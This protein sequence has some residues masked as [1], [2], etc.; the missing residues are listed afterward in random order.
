MRVGG[1]VAGG[2]RGIC[3]LSGCRSDQ[4]REMSR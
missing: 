3:I 1:P 4:T 2:G